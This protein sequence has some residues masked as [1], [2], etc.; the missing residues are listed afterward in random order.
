MSEGPR[1][2]ILETLKSIAGDI[3]S[4]P[5]PADAEASGAEEPKTAEKPAPAPRTPAQKVKAEILS[6]W[7]TADETIDWTDALAHSTPTDRLTTPSLWAFYHK[8]A[9]K[10]LAGDLDAY[11]EVL[12]KANPL[13]E[14]TDYAESI[15]MQ[16]PS[17]DR[18][19]SR[20]VCKKELLDQSRKLYPAAMALRI[21][22]D[23][24]A[25]LPVEEVTVT[26]ECDGK[27][28]I[29]VTF[30][31]QQLLHR[32]FVFTDPIALAKECGASFRQAND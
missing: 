18:L 15:T 22:R 8:L 3:W 24:L 19:E 12:Q 17:P 25:C 10:V 29:S 30:N 4:I 13:G 20:F 28:V 26:G 31:R 11:T 7:K 27:D 9:E 16:A 6:L 32:N 14:L 23:L 2:D 1:K 21:A 5:G